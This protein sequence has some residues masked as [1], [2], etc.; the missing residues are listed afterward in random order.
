MIKKQK[1]HQDDVH[2]MILLNKYNN[3]KYNNTFVTGSKDKTI[4]IWQKKPTLKEIKAFKTND[5]IT[6]LDKL[7]KSSWVFGTRNGKLHSMKDLQ[8]VSDY[9]VVVNGKCKT[10]KQPNQKRV[11]SVLQFQDDLLVASGPELACLNLS[12]N[13]I[14]NYFSVTENDWI[15]CMRKLDSVSFVAAIGDRLA[16]LSFDGQLVS[17]ES[18]IIKMR[19]TSLGR[20]FISDVEIFNSHN[21]HSFACAC[22]D[23][24]VKLVDPKGRVRRTLRGH[25]T[26]KTPYTTSNRVWR[27][28]KRDQNALLSCGD[29]GKVLLWDVRA[30]KIQKVAC[31]TEGRVSSMLLWDPNELLISWCGSDPEATDGAWI[32]IV[33]LRK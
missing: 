4:K 12:S 29:D 30:K 2:G 31:C 20:A 27:C 17:K 1:A 28:I 6:C 11:L 13:E 24:S 32:G 33:D 22:F 7:E 25:S 9:S 8:K 26:I 5:W 19:R 14:V 16:K 10:C 3:T 18:D 15:Y 21:S 23:G